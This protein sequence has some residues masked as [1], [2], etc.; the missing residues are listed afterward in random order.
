MNLMKAT[1]TGNQGQL[2]STKGCCAIFLSIE[3][4]LE[5]GRVN[6]IFP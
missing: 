2:E 1:E 6:F 4:L 5:K 3:Y